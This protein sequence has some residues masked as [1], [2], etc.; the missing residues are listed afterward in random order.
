MLSP[1][2]SECIN[3]CSRL[4]L[5]YHT[6]QFIKIDAQSWLLCKLTEVLIWILRWTKK[7][8]SIYVPMYVCIYVLMYV[9]MYL[10]IYPSNLSF[11]QSIYFCISLSCSLS[12]YISQYLICLVKSLLTFVFSCISKRIF[13]KCFHMNR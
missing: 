2:L 1:S 6:N 10:S 8:T 7:I 13:P 5:S 12:L 4:I 9:Y 11:H 3:F